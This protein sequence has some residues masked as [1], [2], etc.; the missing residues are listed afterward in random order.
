MSHTPVLYGVSHVADYDM[1]IA[2]RDHLIK[3]L[4]AENKRLEVEK[5]QWRTNSRE[6]KMIAEENSRRADRAEAEV[7]RLRETL[8]ATF[9][10]PVPLP[11]RKK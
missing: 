8:A 2:M 7:A 6:N 4:E 5:E 9:A 10:D 11:D 3:K 1:E